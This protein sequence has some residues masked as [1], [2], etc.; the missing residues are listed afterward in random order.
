M[1][2]RFHYTVVLYHIIMSLLW[3]KKIDNGI[4]FP[5]FAE[6]VKKNKGNTISL[7]SIQCN[8]VS[9]IFWRRWKKQ[10][11]ETQFHCI[12]Y[13]ELYFLC[14]LK[15]VQKNG[16]SI[17]LYTIQGNRIS[18][19]LFFFLCASHPQTSTITMSLIA[20]PKQH[21]HQ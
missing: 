2:T 8:R 21:P 4:T 13:K 18:I 7:Y 9:I 12:L 14:F 5:L 16:N 10:T 17:L 15:G 6:G 3:G 20:Q 11:T 1:K 19:C